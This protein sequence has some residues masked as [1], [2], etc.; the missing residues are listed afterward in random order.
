MCLRYSF[1][2]MPFRRTRKTWDEASLYEYAVLALGRRMRSVAE[3]KRLMRQR[4]SEEQ[5]HGELLIE[6]VIARL[7][8]QNY[9]NDTSYA[10]TYVSLRKENSKF[11]RGRVVSELKSRGVHGDIIEKTVSAAYAGVD[12]EK[13]ARDYLKRKR[14]SKPT[15]EKDAA[16][17]FRALARAGFRSRTITSILKRWD[18]EEDLLSALQGESE[19]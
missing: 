11:G 12:E 19:V 2:A 14:L 16:R 10:G 15:S 8:E 9:L 1:L 5:E 7:K 3:L 4:M 18:V 6:V 13:L 17:I